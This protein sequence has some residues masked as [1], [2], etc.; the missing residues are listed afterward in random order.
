M[1]GMVPECW[2][3]ALVGGLAGHLPSWTDRGP[4][5]LVLSACSR[6]GI[7]PTQAAHA[8]VRAHVM[9]RCQVG[10]IPWRIDKTESNVNVAPVLKGTWCSG[11]TPA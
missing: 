8:C 4:V 11:I 9:C 10:S 5:L 6:L 2:W 7:R 1:H 3:P